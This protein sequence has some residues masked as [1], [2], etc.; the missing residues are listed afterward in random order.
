MEHRIWFNYDG[1]VNPTFVG[2][3]DQPT[4]IARTLEDGTTQ[5]HQFEYN[6]L[7]NPTKAIDP[8]G[9]TLT[10]IYD[11]NDVDLTEVRQTRAGQ[12]ELLLSATYNSQHRPLTITDAARQ[13]TSFSYNARGQV[14]TAT[15]ALGHVVSF[16]YDTNGYLLAIDGPL[17]GTSDTSHFTYDNIGRLRIATD[18]DGYTLTFD[19]DELDRLTRV[20]Y[21][22]ATY[23]EI[24]FNRLDTEVLRDR[25]GRETRLTYDSLRQ[26]VSVQDPLGRITHYDWCGCGGLDAVIDPLGRATSW[27]RDLQGRV[28]TKVYAD[29]SQIQYEYDTAMG[30]LKSI[31]DE[32]NQLTMFD[33]NLD[34]TL[35]QKSYLNAL[36]STPNVKFT[37]DPN[38]RRMLT[39]EDGTGLTSLSYHPITG[40]TSLG[41]GR[42]ASIDGPLPNDTITFAYDELGRLVDRGINGVGLHAAWD[43]A[44]RL[45]QATNALG[46]FGFDWHGPSPRLASI[47]YPNGQ[48][49]TLDYHTNTGNFFFKEIAHV[50]PDGNPLSKFAHQ[51]DA[52]G[53]ITNWT[54]TAS[55]RFHIHGNFA[56]MEQTS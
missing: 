36:I 55:Q 33:Y 47:R 18:V 17:P 23:E 6:S 31:R 20:T 29:G 34:G 26:L 1:Q 42:L 35:R 15:N 7:R 54:S 28:K 13:A 4:K 21:P 44:G 3:S 12:N 56:M 37:Y 45:L 48:L 30:R 39:M 8:L 25:G 51:Y 40:N 50:K 19:Y 49:T 10:F 53:R 46:A 2:T 41:A 52:V 11:T 14:L 5:L 9:R 16:S 27:I 22:D 32:Q 38:Y 43:A 24:T